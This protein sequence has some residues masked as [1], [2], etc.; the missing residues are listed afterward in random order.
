MKRKRLLRIGALLCAALTLCG[1]LTGC[2]ASYEERTAFAM[3]SVL[4]ARLYAPKEQADDLFGRM[5]E[6]VDEADRLLSANDPASEL[7]AINAKGSAN[8]SD[9]TR[10][11]LES[12]VLMCNL[13]DGSVDVTMGAVTELWGFS[14]DAPRKPDDA[15][16]QSA[17]ATVGL[18]KL[19]IDD[20]NETVVLGEGQK[21]DPGAFGKGLALDEIAGVLH[22]AHYPAVVS[23]GGSVLLFGVPR[24]GKGW[25]VG[26][27][28]PFRG[29]N[30]YFATLSF[31]P[32]KGDYR[33]FLSTSGSYEKNFT[34]D[35]VT[36]HHIL[37]PETGYPVETG[38]I[39]VTV[40]AEG[41]MAGDALSTACF[42]NGL[43]ETTLQW[44]ENFGAE[45]VFVYQN[46]EFYVTDG[47]RD[48]FTLKDDVFSEITYVG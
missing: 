28:D 12:M 4:T 40:Y 8:A 41:G 30:D 6:R 1:A 5:T 16:L 47:L 48:A 3:G 26:V 44:L 18:Q 22:T 24:S 19:L 35:G 34:E 13:L 10:K 36:Y 25:T 14:T 33:G 37:S 7:A 42:V 39:S 20:D 17:L 46:K 32:D 15:A 29:E 38:L 21:L 27:R 11:S 2:A 9:F 43:N 31:S 23:F 45:A